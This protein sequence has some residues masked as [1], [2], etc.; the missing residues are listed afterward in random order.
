M[1]DIN[2]ILNSLPID[3]IA[4]QLGVDPSVARQAVQQGGAAILTGLQKNATS[5]SG[6]SALETALGQ[7]AN[8]PDSVSLSDVDTHDGQKILGHIFGDQKASVEQTL[9]SEPKTASID[10][11]KLLPILA[12][13]VMGLLAKQMQQQPQQQ[14]SGGIGDIIGSVLG[15]AMGGGSALGGNSSAGSNTSGIDIGSILGSILGGR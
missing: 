11:S 15:S 12:P 3:Q 10:F 2:D 14:S 6:A 4:A 13:I 9:T 8:M 5:A 1:A 7:H